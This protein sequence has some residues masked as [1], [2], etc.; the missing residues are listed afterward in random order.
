VSVSI[1]TGFVAC[2]KRDTRT[3]KIDV[4]VF[5]GGDALKIDVLVFLEGDAL[6]FC[7]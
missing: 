5:L 4:L 6:L 7:L 3:S 2:S 1:G